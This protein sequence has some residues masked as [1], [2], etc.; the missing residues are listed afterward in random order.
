MSNEA[1]FPL[2]V[3]PLFLSVWIVVNI[4]LSLMSGWFQLSRKFPCPKDFQAK[5][6]FRLTTMTLGIP[7]LPVGYRNCIYIRIG[8]AGIK[9]SILFLFRIL[10]PPILIPWREI[11]SVKRVK[12]KLVN[13]LVH[14][15]IVNIRN[16]TKRFRFYFSAGNTIFEIC[17]QKG[18][19][20]EA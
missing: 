14:S 6:S 1:Q 2:W 17:K 5:Y 7:Y 18:I 13:M 15:T 16:D 8:E 9:I 12:P 3:I 20:I 11:E 10:N 4:V 19:R